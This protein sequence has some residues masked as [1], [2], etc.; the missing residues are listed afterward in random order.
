MNRQYLIILTSLLLLGSCS[1]E[2]ITTPASAPIPKSD[3]GVKTFTS[4]NASMGNDATTRLLLTG[5]KEVSWQSDETI[6]IFSDLQDLTDYHLTQGA[7]SGEGTFKGKA[8]AGNSFFAFYPYNQ[9]TTLNRS[10]QVVKFGFEPEV[11]IGNNGENLF[12][13]IIAKSADNSLQFKLLPGIFHFSLNSTTALS[14][15]E[16]RGNSGESLGGEATVEYTASEPLMKLTGQGIGGGATVKKVSANI[17][18]AYQPSADKP[19]DVCF[20]LP[21]GDYSNGITLTITTADGEVVEKATDQ[22]VTLSRGEAK[23]FS[24]VDV[25]KL[26][27][28]KHQALLSFAL[29][30]EMPTEVSDNDLYGLIVYQGDQEVAQ[31]LF[32]DPSKMQLSLEKGKDYKVVATVVKDGKQKLYS[33]AAGYVQPFGSSGTLLYNK[34]SEK[35]INAGFALDAEQFGKGYT[36]FSN[37]S[38]HQY[39]ETERYYG[40]ATISN[41][42]QD[43]QVTIPMI[44]TGF[45]LKF[46]IAEVANGTVD[47]TFKTK[48]DQE[49]LYSVTGIKS[50]YVSEAK[51]FT[52]SDVYT[53]WSNPDNYTE[54][55]KITA[56]W[57]KATG[58]VQD[59]GSKTLKVKRDRITT[60]S[61]MAT[62]DNRNLGFLMDETEFDNESAT[63]HM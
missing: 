52:Y 6:A 23:R 9:N 20:I 12:L 3:G 29:G 36:K 5:G 56:V 14:S 26:L 48:D 4:F 42:T 25:D 61:F 16:L 37:G 19:L 49:T 32:D 46:E 33:N 39:P 22:L 62:D 1:S 55:I 53:T 21:P 41:F 27:Y 40:E 24:T 44:H 59:L 18:N 38:F 57:K 8:V 50:S 2:D 7:G 13:P 45:G 31:G 51:V 47:V 58:E 43:T 60:V 54:E 28:A 10:Q 15:I 34:F 17:D 35:N 11:V 30:G 63:I